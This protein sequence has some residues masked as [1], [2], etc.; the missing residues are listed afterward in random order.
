[1]ALLPILSII[2]LGQLPFPKPE[3]F[4][5]KLLENGVPSLKLTWARKGNLEAGAPPIL[6]LSFS[7]SESQGIN[8]YLKVLLAIILA[9]E[10]L[11]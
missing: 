2:L 7:T 8:I 4:Y 11:R 3:W 1:M 9:Y 5:V 10:S 6:N